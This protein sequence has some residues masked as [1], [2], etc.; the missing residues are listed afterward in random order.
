MH[1]YRLG[2]NKHLLQEKSQLPYYVMYRYAHL[3]KSYF[4]FPMIK[5]F[6]FYIPSDITQHLPSLLSCLCGAYYSY[7][8]P[9][10]S[11]RGGEHCSHYYH[12]QK[13]CS[14]KYIK[15]TDSSALLADILLS[16]SGNH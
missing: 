5:L 16:G 15:G 12:L 3:Y 8:Y 10:S 11:V 13:H 9:L 4:L 7:F 14:F 2:C 6:A 1:P